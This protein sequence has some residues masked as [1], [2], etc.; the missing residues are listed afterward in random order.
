LPGPPELR[1]QTPP[2]GLSAAEGL[3]PMSIQKAIDQIVEAFIPEMEKISKTSESEAQK[4]RHYKAWLRAARIFGL[5]IPATLLARADE[6]I[7]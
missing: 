4:E 1:V 5:E 7:E 3:N 2:E 6:V